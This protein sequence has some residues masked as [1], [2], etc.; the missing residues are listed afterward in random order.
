MPSSGLIN[1]PPVGTRFQ[2]GNQFAKGKGGRSHRMV[3][4]RQELMPILEMQSR[5]GADG[6]VMPELK[7]K[8][9]QIMERLVEM[10]VEGDIRAIAE[11]CKI[12]GFYAPIQTEA[13][14]DAQMNSG[15]D[16]SRL[17]P[18]QLLTVREIIA[19]TQTSTTFS[20]D[21]VVQ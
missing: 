15:I 17:T 5:I 8:A 13:K 19:A 18:E 14:L 4:L 9:A 21:D 2:K 20:Q 11:I 3:L 10:A 6:E 7:S 16:L 1:T 12:G